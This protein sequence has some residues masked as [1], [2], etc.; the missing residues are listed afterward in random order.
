MMFSSC[1]FWKDGKRLWSVKHSGD[2][3]VF[4]IVRS[5]KVP[6]QYASIKKALVEKQKSDGGEKADVDHVFELPLQLAK[7]LVGFRHDEPDSTGGSYELLELNYFERAARTAAAAKSWL[8]VA[9]VFLGTA[10]LIG[11]IGMVVRVSF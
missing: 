4:N 8:Y 7:D 10:V 1:A 9:G 3:G 6:R 5:G 2:E 11:L